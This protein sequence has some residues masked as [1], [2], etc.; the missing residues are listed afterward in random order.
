MLKNLDKIPLTEGEMPL[1]LFKELEKIWE[2]VGW[3][4]KAI[5]VPCKDLFVKP[6]YSVEDVVCEDEEAKTKVFALINGDS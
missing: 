6:P 2:D 4:G 5:H 3:V 1:N